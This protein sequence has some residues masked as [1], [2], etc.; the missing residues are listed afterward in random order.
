MAKPTTIIDAH[1]HV[2]WHG[3]DDAGLV[4]N[5]DECGIAKSVVLTWC[6]SQVEESVGYEAVFNPVHWEHAPAGQG[7]GLPFSDALA[8]VRRY[9]DR[10]LL[11]Y[12][13]HPVH[14]HCI[15][16]LDAAVRM[17]DVRVCGE[18]KCRL[19]LD[20]PRCI[21]LF[22]YCGAHGLAVQLH[23]DVPWFK[24]PAT[25]TLTYDKLWYGGT[26]DNLERAL[27]ACPET[28]FLG[29]GPGFWREMSGDAAQA[30]PGY[31][32]GKVTPGGKVVRLLDAYPNLW[33]DMSGNSGLNSLRRDVDHAGKF[34]KTYHERLLFARDDYVNLLRPFLD[35]LD[36]P[37][38]VVENIY[39]RNAEK[40]Y[41][42]SP[43]PRG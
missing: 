25:G 29:H 16:W 2:F 19:T 32:T 39:H 38:D 3:R 30:G 15:E 8:T 34:L 18:W 28:I 20:D 24:N 35:S 10:L 27:Q 40:V 41:R 22:R 4:A 7:I 43:T 26:I 9:P 31:P 36:L 42:I 6:L 37:T 14:E 5:M 1:Q 21:E 17:Y 11:G 23:I 33:G 12:C 13:P